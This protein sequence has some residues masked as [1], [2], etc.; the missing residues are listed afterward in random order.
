MKIAVTGK[1]GVGK[2]T[3]CALLARELARQGKRVLAIDADPNANLGEAL[4]Y[5]EETSGR[6]EP[7]I[8]KKALVEER[9]GTKPGSMGGFFVLN[10]K[11][12]DLVE[13]FSVGIKGL[14]LIV[15]GELKEAL[16]GCY[17]PENAL[18]RS[19]LRHLMVERDEWVILDMEAGFEHLTRGTAESVGTLLIV[20]EPGQRAMNT[21]GKIASLAKQLH[22]R[23]V[24][25]VINKVHS[26]GQKKKVADK[27]DSDAIW[28]T[29]PFD[30]LALEADLS[31]VSPYD[32]CPEMLEKIK[33]LVRRLLSDGEE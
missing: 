20:V 33:G 16:G 3:L 8:E 12:D 28:A 7:L 27:L 6:I 1:G 19:F 2:T 17:C 25:Y 15:T 5:D 18:L 23:K 13:R 9:T 31:G 10:P 4:G 32:Q 22:I 11:V 26:E 24:G 30:F 21:A 29:I 14:R